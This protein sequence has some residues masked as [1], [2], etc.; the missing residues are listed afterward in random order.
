[1][2]VVRTRSI[3][4]VP[5]ERLVDS[6]AQLHHTLHTPEG[7]RAFDSPRRTMVEMGVKARKIRR[8]LGIRGVPV[9]PCPHCDG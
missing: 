4:N 6:L 3:P 9:P 5:D 2:R 7:L 8:E 1:M